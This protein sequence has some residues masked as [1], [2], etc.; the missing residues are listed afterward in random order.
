MGP[1][2][3]SRPSAEPEDRVTRC[4][5]E[6]LLVGG[7]RVDAVEEHADL[8]LPAPQVGAQD[9][10]LHLVGHLGRGEDLDPA[11]EV[12]LPATG[13]PHVPNPLRVAAGGHEV[14]LALVPEQVAGRGPPLAA[15]AP[16][17]VKDTR[18][19][20]ADAHPGE[21]GDDPAGDA[22][23]EV[24]AGDD[25][26]FG[27]GH[28]VLLGVRASTASRA[29]LLL[30]NSVHAPGTHVKSTALKRDRQSHAKKATILLVRTR[31]EATRHT[32]SALH[33]RTCARAGSRP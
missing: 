17:D 6:Q 25:A 13:H 33:A 14:A 19:Q 7:G 11:A 4:D 1:S 24:V 26:K 2:G 32:R 5:L 29:V 16:T 30:E 21:A 12:Q 3:R 27:R 15:L 20:Q 10:R 18:A 23:R 22:V 8:E 31:S 28:G 9:L